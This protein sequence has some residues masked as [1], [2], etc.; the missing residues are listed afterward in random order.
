[1]PAGMNGLDLAQEVSERLPGVPIL[2][3]SGY[4]EAA[5]RGEA[6]FDE[7]R[8]FRILR[9]PVPFAELEAAVQEELARVA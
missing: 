4:N 5:I 3:M 7:L 9:K 8:R 2:L 6:G 1:M